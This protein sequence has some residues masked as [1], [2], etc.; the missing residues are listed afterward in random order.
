LLSGLGD[1]SVAGR[2]SCSDLTG[3]D[4]QGEVPRTD[5]DNDTAPMSG[6]AI[7]LADRALQQLGLS[8]LAL[9]Q[10]R[11]VAAEIGGFPNLGDAVSYRLARFGGTDCNEA[12]KVV[13]QGLGHGTQDRRAPCPATC[14]PGGLGL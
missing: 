7:D 8:E 4:S 14:I 2:Q 1:H 10:I 3:E 13:L 9:R 6:Q 11:I 12:I 5:R